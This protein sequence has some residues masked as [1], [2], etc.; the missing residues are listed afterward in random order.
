VKEETPP[1]SLRIKNRQTTRGV[2]VVNLLFTILEYLRD[3]LMRFDKVKSYIRL[4]C[5]MQ[6]KSEIIT[7]ILDILSLH[8]RCVPRG[9]TK[10]IS[11]LTFQSITWT[12]AIFAR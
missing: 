7:V 9:K 2:V 10:Y 5:H 1:T 4:D 3:L 6:D 11:K 12:K 8:V